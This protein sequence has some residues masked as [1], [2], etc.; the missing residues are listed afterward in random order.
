MI[1]GRRIKPISYLKSHAA[2]VLRDLAETG[3]PLVITQNGEGRAVLLDI[4]EYEKQRENWL[5]ASILMKREAQ[6]DRE[7]ARPAEEVFEEIRKK[8]R[9]DTQ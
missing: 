5:I 6:G 1:D 8:R 7:T 2:E 9:G 3:K 4:N